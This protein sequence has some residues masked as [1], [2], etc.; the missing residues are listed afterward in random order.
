MKKIAILLP[1][2]VL[3][4]FYFKPIYRGE[5]GWFKGQGKYRVRHLFHVPCYDH[6]SLLKEDRIPFCRD[7]FNP[8]FLFMCSWYLR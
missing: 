2:F 1:V 3:A 8:V 4:L 5:Y 6:W 7:S